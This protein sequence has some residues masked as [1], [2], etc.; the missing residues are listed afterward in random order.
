MRLEHVPLAELVEARYRRYRSLGLFTTV[1]ETPLAPPDR[2]G[3][4]D[5]LRNL[6][7]VG[8]QTLG[9]SSGRG[10]DEVQPPARDEV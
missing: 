2:P 7:E 1:T 3:L 9:G 8:R 10:R 4:T 5:R 6:L